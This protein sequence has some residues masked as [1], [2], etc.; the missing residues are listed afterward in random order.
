MTF[1]DDFDEPGTSTRSVWLPHYL[2]A[3]EL[4][5]GDGGDLRGPGR[6][7][8]APLR[9]AGPGPVAPRAST[10]RRCASPAVQTGNFSG[11]AGSTVGQQPWR[12]GAVVRE[13]Q[14]ALL[15]LDAG[16]RPARDAGARRAPRRAP[17][18]PGRW[19]ASR[20]CLERCAEICVFEVFG[21]ARGTRDVEPRRSVMGLHAFR[22]PGTPEDFA[23]VRLPIDVAGFHHRYRRR[24]DAR[25]G[26]VLRGRPSSSAAARPLRPRPTR[27]R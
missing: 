8:T 22:D 5:G 16:P 13:Q 14:E 21:D 15:G 19:S 2:P 24:L 11:P 12:P 25:A 9:P 7:A 20:T 3:V 6:V 10:S 17:W 18:R 27:C 1:A 26:G 4:A 23:A